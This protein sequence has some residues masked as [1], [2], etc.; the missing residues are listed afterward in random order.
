MIQLSVTELKDK[1]ILLNENIANTQLEIFKEPFSN[2][3]W[4]NIALTNMIHSNIR[5]FINMIDDQ[6]FFMARATMRMQLNCLMRLFSIFIIVPQEKW[7]DTLLFKEDSW[8]CKIYKDGKPQSISETFLCKQLEKYK[9]LP[10]AADIYKKYSKFIHPSNMH[11][12]EAVTKWDSQ[13]GNSV[14]WATRINRKG[15]SEKTDEEIKTYIIE[16]ITITEIINKYLAETK[17][18]HNFQRFRLTN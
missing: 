5:A 16:M 10:N 12:N 17:K 9:I 11:F 8:K 7:I 1:L 15:I 2:I 3:D 18:E 13:K 4:F 6:N 14:E